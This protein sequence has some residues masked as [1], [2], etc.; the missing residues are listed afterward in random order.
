MKNITVLKK[1]SPSG[2]K[3]GS[4]KQ[5][6]LSGKEFVVEERVS[7]FRGDDEIYSLHESCYHR[8]ESQER[9]KIQR[10]Q[11]AAGRAHANRA[12]VLMAFETECYGRGITIQK[13][14]GDSHWRLNGNIDWWPNTGTTMKK[15]KHLGYIY[16]KEN[17]KL[18][19]L[20]K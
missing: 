5:P 18:F 1:S 7:W 2:I 13:F 16:P 17:Y 15:G 20:I 10:Q 14:N 6:I 9:A 3:C 19:A 4:C 11:Q 8:M 12:K